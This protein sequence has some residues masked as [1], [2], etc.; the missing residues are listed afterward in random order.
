MQFFRKP[1]HQL[2]ILLFLGIAL[3]SGLTRA[4]PVYTYADLGKK[5][6]PFGAE[7]QGNAAGTIPAWQD[8]PERNWDPAQEKPLFVITAE[9]YR[10]H[11]QYLTAGQQAL[12]TRYPTS[13]RM[14]VYPS[15]RDFVP[16]QR[17]METTIAN[18]P[19]MRISEGGYGITGGK[20]GI[21]FPI[22]SQGIEALWTHKARFIGVSGTLVSRDAIV[23]PD[24]SHRLTLTQMDILFNYY[25]DL[26]EDGVLWSSKHSFVE[27]PPHMAGGSILVVEPLDPMVRSRQTWG[28]NQGERRVR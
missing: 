23:E 7:R 27:G 8:T 19:R 6:T 24:G 18:A 17:V 11:V 16:P 2:L 15:R 14:P 3:A 26:P 12:F 25:T 4:A 1:H 5:L 28:Y 22:P 13:F 9:N 10:Q 20:G 21:P